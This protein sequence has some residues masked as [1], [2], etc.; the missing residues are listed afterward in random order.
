MMK[1]GLNP[2]EKLNA[3]LEYVGS[4]AT[5]S[6]PKCRLQIMYHQ[7]PRVYIKDRRLRQ[8]IYETKI[9]QN[10]FVSEC[11]MIFLSQNM[12][13][14]GSKCKR[15]REAEQSAASIAIEYILQHRI[16]HLYK[17]IKRPISDFNISISPSKV[18]LFDAEN[19]PVPK[20]YDVCRSPDILFIFFD[21]RPTSN[22]VKYQQIKN[23]L[24]MKTPVR[25]KDAC[26]IHIIFSA[27]SLQ[28]Q[29]GSASFAV[30]TKDHFGSTLV[31]LMTN[32]VLI[33]NRDDLHHFIQTC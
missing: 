6:T 23:C 30:A 7:L 13:F 8:P 31:H 11:K 28:L 16:E 10:Q 5:K 29:H 25:G 22:Y 1:S 4:V 14:T 26:D 12:V 32:T 27:K 19:F 3:G 17:E 24:I 20:H 18:I 21:A 2:D 9:H 15:K 33:K